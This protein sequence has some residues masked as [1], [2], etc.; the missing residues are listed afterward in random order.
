[1]VPAVA[2]AVEVLVAVAVGVGVLVAVV[3]PAAAV[4]R[5]LA[6][7][8]LDYVD[9]LGQALATRLV[10]R[11]GID[12]APTA[13]EVRKALY[14]AIIDVFGDRGAEQHA[15]RPSLAVASNAEAWFSGNLSLSVPTRPTPDRPER[16]S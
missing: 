2:L 12:A 9:R 7:M 11:L 6:T 15:N 5:R 3:A 14:E 1:M 10:V 8:S 13:D 4:T 16:R